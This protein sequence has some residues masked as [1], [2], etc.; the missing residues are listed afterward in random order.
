M[1]IYRYIIRWKNTNG[2]PHTSL[3]YKARFQLTSTAP[4]V[5]ADAFDL[6]TLPWLN[7][8]P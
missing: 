4:P 3:C 7:L 2:A 5:Y 1:K 6:D 8:T